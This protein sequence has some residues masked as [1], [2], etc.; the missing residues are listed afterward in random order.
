MNR[1]KNC[2]FIGNYEIVHYDCPDYQDGIITL[3]SDGL[4]NGK[5]VAQMIDGKRV[6]RD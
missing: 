1:Y 5:I 3:V 2:R 4:D 6:E